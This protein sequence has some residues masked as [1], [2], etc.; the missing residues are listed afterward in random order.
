MTITRAALL[1]I[2]NAEHGD[3]AD[4]A[5]LQAET[6]TYGGWKTILDDVFRTL[7]TAEADLPTASLTDAQTHAG[8]VLL[9]Y[10]TLRRTLRSLA[11]KQ[12]ENAGATGGIRSVTTRYTQ[13]YAQ[14]S[15]RLDEVRAQVVAMG[16]GRAAD[17]LRAP[18]ITAIP[19]TAVG[20]YR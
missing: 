9:E 20:T 18:R 19:N 11:T 15:D 3:L 5:K 8:L 10:Y 17:I 1:E 13:I 4:Q 2:A 14:Y 7:G 16:Y 12:N 6:D